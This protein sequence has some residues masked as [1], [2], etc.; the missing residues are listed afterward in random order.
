[1][2]KH[3][4]RTSHAI[5]TLVTQHSNDNYKERTC[6]LNITKAVKLKYIDQLLPP[7][8]IRGQFTSPKGQ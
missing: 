7:T 1:M 6:E 2:S 4:T 8:K 3:K 5:S